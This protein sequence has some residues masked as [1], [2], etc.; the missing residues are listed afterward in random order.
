M[1]ERER[2]ARAICARLRAAGHRALFAGGCVRDRLLGITPKDFDVATSALPDQVAAL[3]PRTIAVGAAF[4]V[5]LVQT[6]AGPVEVATFR[7]D[8]PY[9]DGRHPS[10]VTFTGEREDAA[11][12]DFTI[13]A[14]YLDPETDTVLDYVDGLADLRARVVRAVGDPAARF[15]EDHLRLLRAVRFAA[16][17]DFSIEPRTLAAI[18]EH[19][20]L[21]IDTSAERVRDELLK[22]L[23]EGHA[24]RAF[25]LLDETGLL[26]HVLPE[27]IPMKGC[28]QPPEYHPEG[29][30]FVH[31]LLLLDQLGECSPA[32]ALAALLHDVGKPPTQTFEDRIRFNLHEK[33]GARMAEKICKRL[34]LPNDVSER[35]V[36]LVEN[37]MR[38]AA[39]P[40]MR[41]SKRKRFVREPGYDELLALG[42]MDCLAS[43]GDTSHINWIEEYRANLRPDEIRPAPL[44]TGNDLIA[45]G[46]PPGPRF[47]EIL[48]A[49][50]DLQLEGRLETPEAARA[51]VEMTWPQ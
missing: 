11:R 22:M 49:V 1:N 46:Y 5:I 14:L 9:L 51:H 29:D 38:L 17:L 20:P 4:G 40:E 33:V 7:H 37:H 43:H 26:E 2:A 15:R 21:C 19:A 12:R 25:E 45:M 24:K 18:R 10:A 34:R 31:T 50:E 35:A 16:R 3:F 42:R 39:T 48:T 23:T 30:V 41:E 36:W 6:E 13:N 47:K 44:I 8:G 27:M 32:L 28:E